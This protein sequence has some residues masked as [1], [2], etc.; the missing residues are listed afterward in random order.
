[1][2]DLGTRVFAGQDGADAGLA[3]GDG[4]EGDAG[5]HD[6]GVEEGARK[7]H[8]AAA[9]ADDDGCDRGLA[10]G[11]SH[12]ADVEAETAEFGFE[13]AGI[14]PEALDALGLFLEEIEGR[15]TGRGDGRRM[16]GREEEW[17]GAVV[18]EVN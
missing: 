2:L 5:G 7:I 15:D 3:F 14:F 1:M 9:V 6:S 12:A 17:A 4:R 10:C 16:R 11:G 13:V 8:G 18:E